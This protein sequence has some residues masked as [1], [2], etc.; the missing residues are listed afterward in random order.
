MKLEKLITVPEGLVKHFYNLFKA[1]KDEWFCASDPASHK[2]GSGGGT[3][4]ILASCFKGSGFKGSFR[5]WLDAKKR[6]V[7]HSGGQSR[8]LPAYAAVGKS[9]IP[10]PVFRWSKG[11]Y[12]DQKLLDFQ[13]SFYE[14]I[15]NNA[16]DRYRILIGSGDVMF[17]TDEKFYDLPEADVICFGL[18]ADDDTTVRHGVFF[19]QKDDP[20]TLSFMIQKPDK[21]QLNKLAEKYYYLMDSGIWML[22]SKAVEILMLKCGWD[23]EKSDFSD[24]NCSFY[25]LYSTM[26]TAFGKDPLVKD[27]LLNAL[28]VKIISMNS[29][30]FFHFGS[31]SELIN[32][33]NRIQNRVI[34][35]RKIWYQERKHHPSIYQ[36]N[37]DVRVRFNENN[38]NI[39]IDNSFVSEGWTLNKN[40]VITN[41]PENNWNLNLPAGIC[42]DMVMVQ[43]TKFCLKIY[44]FYDTF[45]G[46][47]NEDAGYM[48][49]AL[50]NWLKER[51][52]DVKE[53]SPAA[54][55]DIYYLKLFPVASNVNEA[56]EIMNWMI[57]GEDKNGRLLWLKA[58]RL[59]ADDLGQCIDTERLEAQRRAFKNVSLEK[60]ICN[61]KNSIFYQM[62]LKKAAN[63]FAASSL[64]VPAEN[65]DPKSL[66]KSIA[67]K[68]FRS[69]TVKN[70]VSKEKYE[71]EAFNILR[72]EIIDTV[73]TKNF[74][75]A[76]RDILDD[77]IIWA[78]SPVRLDLAGGWTDTPPYCIFNGGKVVNI[79]ININGQSPLQVF[80]RPLPEFKIVLKS[81]DLGEKEEINTFEDLSDYTKIGKAFSIPKAA[82]ILAG[83]GDLYG[84][85]RFKSL[86][87]QLESFGCGIE[88]TLL[89]AVPK[90]SGLGTSS[91]LAGTCLGALNEFF[92]LGWD[93]HE[94]AYRTIILEQMLTAG[95]GWQDQYG[96]IFHGIKLVETSPGI[97][98]KPS[99]KWLPE[100]LFSSHEYKD[101]VLLYYTGVTRIA[102]GIL[103]EIVKGMF[104]NS[105]PH[106]SILSTMETHAMETYNVIMKNDYEGMA[107]KVKKSWEL[108]QQLDPGTNP[109]EIQAIAERIHDYLLGFKLIGA[110]GGGYMVMM[111]K[112]FEAASKVRAILKANPANSKARFVDFDVSQ[113]GFEISRS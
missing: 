81:I 2:L 13:A 49:G 24:G 18:W 16:P 3:A 15:F 4:N 30:E 82:F 55:D 44:G 112:D 70:S 14:G 62:D 72:K 106:L 68:M 78:R 59:S 69:L 36:I 86:K 6:I 61:S 8:R 91:I 108:N 104:V 10:V 63:D 80:A 87:S 41:I 46:T 57:S 66:A 29:I 71:S 52:I 17:I 26:S 37:S 31:N 111:A 25:D 21:K 64:V 65:G 88:F 33:F 107:G 28:D 5:D 92:I 75:F 85:N 34:D 79:A 101:L 51:D 35:Q 76:S 84:G 50:K 23:P 113:T 67:D 97:V 1:A 96:G 83:F 99:I 45:R 105:G 42:I 56:A 77:Q 94:I 60:M 47:V 95:G 38:E 7:I 53:I 110:G 103:A 109:P 98:Q 20:E 48:N 9:M 32:S 39:W 58:E 100:T 12:L 27:P 11:Q 89:S 73:R 40:H 93:K 43:K 74:G 22:S 54:Q 90:G 102:K 19:S